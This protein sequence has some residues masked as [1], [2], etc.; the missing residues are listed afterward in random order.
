[1]RGQCRGGAGPL[2]SQFIAGMTN[3]LGKQFI[4]QCL[5]PLGAQRR[6]PAFAVA[7][8]DDLSAVADL[9][10]WHG[11]LA[12]TGAVLRLGGHRD[13][14]VDRRRL[15]IRLPCCLLQLSAIR[16]GCRACGYAACRFGGTFP[17]V[18][19]EV[20]MQVSRHLVEV[21]ELARGIEIALVECRL[22]GLG[23][24]L[25]CRSCMAAGSQ[26]QTGQQGCRRNQRFHVRSV[27]LGVFA[28]SAADAY[29]GNHGQRPWAGPW[30]WERVPTTVLRST[31]AHIGIAPIQPI[32]AIR[33]GAM[34]GFSR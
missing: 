5:V 31:Q 8:G 13:H 27:F 33:T 21:G 9:G 4:D 15:R 11:H 28:V 22:H 29:T 20:E 23:Q 32:P 30:P 1:M 18:F 34:H 14:A 24:Y 25:G 16:V 17:D 19:E 10:A 26:V 12:G 7:D 3:A 2:G 6:T